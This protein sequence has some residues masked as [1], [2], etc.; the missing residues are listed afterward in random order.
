LPAHTEEKLGENMR[1]GEGKQKNQHSA[2]LGKLYIM[3]AK[4]ELKVMG[5]I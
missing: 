2:P 5:C 3:L 4:S 1:V